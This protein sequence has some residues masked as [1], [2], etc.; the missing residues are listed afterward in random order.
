VII[1]NRGGRSIGFAPRFPSPACNSYGEVGQQSRDQP[2]CFDFRIRNSPHGD[3]SN[4][5]RAI[6][7]LSRPF[8]RHDRF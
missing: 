7:T 1:V 5:R 8:Q 2:F 4:Y 6:L 3:H